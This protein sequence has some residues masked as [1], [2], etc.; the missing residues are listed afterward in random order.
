MKY[1]TIEIEMF[2]DIFNNKY[3][4]FLTNKIVSIIHMWCIF[5][6]NNLIYQNIAN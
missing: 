1:T 3:Y 2:N 6:I 4:E 5:D